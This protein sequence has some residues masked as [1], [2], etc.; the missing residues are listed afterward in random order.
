MTTLFECNGV[1]ACYK[2]GAHIY[3]FTG[4]PIYYTASGA[5]FAHGSGKPVGW[6]ADGYLYKYDGSPPLY[7][8]V[9]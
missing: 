4:L 5:V 1:A 6:I 3:D 8:G 7:F 2:Q 9:D